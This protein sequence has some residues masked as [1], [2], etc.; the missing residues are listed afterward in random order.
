MCKQLQAAS[1]VISAVLIALAVSSVEVTPQ[2]VACL[3]T[4][5]NGDVQGTATGSSCTFLGIPFAATPIGD[6]TL[7]AAAAG[8]TLGTRHT[9]C[10]HRPSMSADQSQPEA[11]PRWGLRIASS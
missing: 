7:E 5:S 6:L 1:A 3:V 10:G 11:R 8:C 9:D 2:S 4:T